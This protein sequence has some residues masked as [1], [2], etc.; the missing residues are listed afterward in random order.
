MTKNIYEC[1]DYDNLCSFD[2]NEMTFNENIIKNIC[3]SATAEIP[4][5]TSFIGG[6][7]CQE[8]IKSTGKFR[9]INQWEIFDFLQYSSIVPESEKWNMKYNIK[10]NDNRY[11]EFISIFGN[12]ILQKLQNSN[13]FLAGAGALGCEL[14]KNLALLGIK[15]SVLVI[16]DDNIEISNLN[17]QILF[18]EE[19][20]GLNKAFIACNSA[21]EINSDLICNYL[22]KRIS[23][24]NKNIFNK[25]Y[26]DKV[27]FVLGAIDSK[28]GNYYLVK[29]C[30]LFE[31]IFIKGGTEG[32]A[33]KIEVFIP[34][35][36]CSYNDI[37]FHEEE[38]DKS[39]SCT[40][41][42]F[43]SK[44]E[45]CIDNARD[46]FDESFVISIIDLLKIING[47]KI[48]KLEIEHSMYKFNLINIFIYFIKKYA[49]KNNDNSI[50]EIDKEFFCFGLE[51]FKR[52]FFDEIQK[53]FDEHPLND[54]EESKEFWKNKRIPSK[55]EFNINDEL[56]INFLFNYLKIISNLINIPFINDLIIFK[57]QLKT[58]LEEINYNSNRIDYLI[59]DPEI[60]YK[61]ISFEINLIR[62]NSSL[63]NKYNF[64]HP[65]NFEKDIPELGH[66]LFIHS[67]ANLKAKSYKIP[68]CNKFYTLEYAGKIAPTTITSTA[69]AA[70]FMCLQMIGIIINQL[71]FWGKE[72]QINKIDYDEIDDEELI[73]NGLH[74]TNEKIIRIKIC[75]IILFY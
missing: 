22:S 19:H 65:T 23:P 17:R 8:I 44:I 49:E 6:V 70:G 11:D 59:N 51:E 35:M 40:R 43:P 12:N 21:K 24:E 32:P 50:K 55:L 2:K 61:K 41:R 71:Y 25:S 3:F 69:V 58:I 13:I 10:K 38:E 7:V 33:G 48:L 18:H 54:S 20:K 47:N 28:E 31:K 62:N 64:L 1:L 75:R 66:I 45:D 5:M 72:N 39:P 4:C 15:N 34:N 9:P 60:L 29:Q 53:I 73:E 46:L 63:L 36:T 42:Q 26:F 37:Q 68:C 14:L 16:D 67:Y 56:H 30:E 74:T 57:K 52:L 27:D